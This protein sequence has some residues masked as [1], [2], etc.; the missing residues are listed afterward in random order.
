MSDPV[1]SCKYSDITVFSFHP[2]KMITTAEGGMA[3]TNKKEI[4]EKLILLR[5]HGITRNSKYY[6]DK[7]QRDQ[8]WYYE[9]LELGFNYRMNDLQA[10]LGMSQLNRLN[11]F[12]KKRNSIARFYNKKLI[13]LPIIL[14]TVRSNTS[15]SFHLYII[16]INKELKKNRNTI[17]KKLLKL[18]I[19]VNV[20]YI[21]IHLQPFFKKQG[22]KLGQ[23]KNSE[24]FYKNSIT[25]PLHVGLKKFQ[26]NKIIS[27]IK[28]CLKS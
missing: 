6:K 21:P 28:K 20:H 14:P 8:K 12:V 11:F 18:G 13:D 10:A 25:I 9:Q 1:G 24:N 15:S 26:L 19:G 22:F 17:F 27:S 23:F 7:K 4:Y 2:V 16:Q 5:S 3:M